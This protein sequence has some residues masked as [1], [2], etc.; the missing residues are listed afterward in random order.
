[1]KNKKIKILM[2]L[3]LVLSFLLISACADNTNNSDGNNIDANNG[4]N[5]VDN[6]DNNQ[7]DNDTEIDANPDQDVDLT[8]MLLEDEEILNGKIYLRD[9]WAIGA[10]TLKDEVSQDRA[11]EIAKK[12]ANQIKEKYNDKKVNVQV[13]LNGENV[14]N[15]EL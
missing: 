8:N 12:Y 9:E 3:I 15:I 4:N 14:A 1:M 2:S 11:Q 5:G 10:I 7:E 6:N 13:I